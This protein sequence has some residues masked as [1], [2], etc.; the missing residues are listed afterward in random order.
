MVAH[1]VKM[2][3]FNLLDSPEARKAYEA[4]LAHEHQLV[5]N[6]G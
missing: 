4:W 3:D 5:A 2:A 6:D 1:N